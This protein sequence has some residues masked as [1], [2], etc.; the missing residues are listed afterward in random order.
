M[1]V[2]GVL[3]GPV[4]RMQP[5]LPQLQAVLAVAGGAAAWR[6][7]EEAQHVSVGRPQRSWSAVDGLHGSQVV[8]VVVMVVL[9]LLLLMVLLCG[10]GVGPKGLEIVDGLHLLVDDPS[11]EPVQVR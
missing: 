2:G 7:V 4:Q 9:L 3:A 6:E 5:Q 8:V 1:S 11:P 10:G